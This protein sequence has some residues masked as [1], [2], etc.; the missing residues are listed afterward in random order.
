MID[1]IVNHMQ[2]LKEY[3]IKSDGIATFSKATRTKHQY[4]Y[5]TISFRVIKAFA[6]LA[7]KF[8]WY[9]QV[10]PAKNP[11]KRERIVDKICDNNSTS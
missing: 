9:H 4:I 7:Q 1:E 3:S 2:T 6:E 11:Y 5:K 8:K 10:H